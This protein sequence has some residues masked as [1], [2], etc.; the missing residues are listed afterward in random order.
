MNAS[1]TN[2]AVTR[3]SLAATR[4]GVSGTPTFLIN[5]VEIE[6]YDGAEL[7]DRVITRALAKRPR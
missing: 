7:M 2:D 6:G 3:D 1:A 5:D 4:L